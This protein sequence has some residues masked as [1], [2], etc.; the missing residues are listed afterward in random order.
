[1]NIPLASTFKSK[2]CFNVFINAGAGI[3]TAAGIGDYRGK[4][5]KWTEM[6]HEQVSDKIEQIFDVQGPSPSERC[7]PEKEPHKAGALH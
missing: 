2:Q 7:H 3:S 1:M 4:S 6:D 5:G